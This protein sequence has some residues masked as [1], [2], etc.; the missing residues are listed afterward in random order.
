MSLSRFGMKSTCMCEGAEPTEGDLT[1]D[2]PGSGS[3]PGL[4]WSV[5]AFT[6]S[7]YGHNALLVVVRLG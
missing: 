5:S 1:T 4:P 2:G 6:C 3:E 7:R